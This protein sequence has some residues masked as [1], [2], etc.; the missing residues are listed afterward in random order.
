MGSDEEPGIIPLAVRDIFS[1]IASEPQ[2][3]WTLKVSYLEIYL[4]NLR[5]LLA[6]SVVGQSSQKDTPGSQKSQ[7]TPSNDKQKTRLAVPPRADGKVFVTNLHEVPV[8]SIQDVHDALRAGEDYRSVA[9]TDWNH[10]SS[11]SHCIFSIVSAAFELKRG[12]FT[13]CV[14]SD[15]RIR[16]SFGFPCRKICIVFVGIE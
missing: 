10:R 1:T 12:M 4:E 8:S 7:H 15:Y 13:F 11:R 3:V 9:A 14:H 2:R 5:D 6:P 16:T